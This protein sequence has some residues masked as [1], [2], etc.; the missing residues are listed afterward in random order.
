MST[1]THSHPR[2]QPL[3]A[4]VYNFHILSSVSLPLLFLSRLWPSPIDL[5]NL[6]RN[7]AGLI[8]QQE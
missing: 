8:T 4:L 1:I 3:I 5:Q 6:P 2:V 7:V